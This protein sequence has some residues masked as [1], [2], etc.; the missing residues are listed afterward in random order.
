MYVIAKQPVCFRSVLSSVL[1]E[2]AILAAVN[3][4]TVKQ[5]AQS[6][7]A[8]A[9]VSTA[10]LEIL[11]IHLLNFLICKYCCKFEWQ[12]AGIAPRTFLTN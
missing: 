7:R 12:R 9:W 2:D 8:A 4:Y 5:E 10:A 3:N 6:S 11:L 1:A